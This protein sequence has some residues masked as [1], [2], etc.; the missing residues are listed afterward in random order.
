[1]SNEFQGGPFELLAQAAA[2][3]FMLAREK[4][5]R[6]ALSFQNLFG[7]GSMRKAERR[8]RAQ[9]QRARRVMHHQMMRVS[10]GPAMEAEAIAALR[11]RGG[12]ENPL[13]RRRF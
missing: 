11:G 9:R 13:D 8:A 12:P 7:D 6:A 5:R 2:D 3:T 4:K 10:A 1:M